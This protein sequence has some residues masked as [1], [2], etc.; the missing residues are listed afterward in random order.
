M[1]TRSILDFVGS[2]CH[3]IPGLG[4]W[5]VQRQF[6]TGW[7]QIQLVDTANPVCF[8][9]QDFFLDSC[10]LAQGNKYDIETVRHV[11]Q[12]TFPAVDEQH[13]L[14][15]W[16]LVASWGSLLEI[17]QN[18]CKHLYWHGQKVGTWYLPLSIVHKPGKSSYRCYRGRCQVA[19]ID[20]S[21]W[22]PGIY[23]FFRFAIFPLYL[24]NCGQRL[25]HTDF[26]P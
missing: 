9:D 1:A 16:C 3:S 22:S 24:E 4:W 26:L 23:Y 13:S 15:L 19:I 12:F 20:V 8:K 2:R 17:T 18:S 7:R 25:Q 10:Y 6:Q 5:S 14:I 11:K 21:F